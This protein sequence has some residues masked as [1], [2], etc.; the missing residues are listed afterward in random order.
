[1]KRV[2]VI[3]TC[4]LLLGVAVPAWPQDDTSDSRI[5]AAFARASA[6]GIPV[7]LLESK[8]AEGKAKGVPMDRIAGAIERRLAGLERAREALAGRGQVNAAD[9]AVAADALDSG[10]SAAVLRAIAESAP[11][12]RRAVA[13]AALTQ[14]V[15]LGHVPERALEQVREAL[16]RGPQALADLPVQAAGSSGKPGPRDG[17]AP[18]GAAA[19]RAG[20]PGK[21]DGVGPGTSAG[22][23]GVVGGPAV[24]PGPPVGVPAP[25]NAP[26]A[27]KPGGAPGKVPT[28]GPPSGGGN[29]RP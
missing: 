10:V 1:M 11:Q 15:Q 9:L 14:L 25:G 6:T 21:P 20:A 18:A 4:A 8:L 2:V 28:P 3:G 5:A 29:G 24:P 26:E 12:E 17:S 7:G 22:P 27:G 16:Q 23:G 13:I 19:G